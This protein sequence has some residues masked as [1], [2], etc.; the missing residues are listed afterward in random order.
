MMPTW[1]APSERWLWRMVDALGGMLGGLAC[2]DAPASVHHTAWGDVPVLDLGRRA[3]PASVQRGVLAVR[4]FLEADAGRVALVHYLPFAMR[5]GEAWAGLPNRIYVHAH[6]YDLTEDLR[7]PGPDGLPVRFHP[8]DYAR[9]VAQLA[10]RLNGGVLLAN[11][12]RSREKLL[13]MGV[14]P[15]KVM[16]KYLGVPVPP[17]PP[18]RRLRP[19]GMRLLFLGR[20]VDFKGPGETV[21]AFEIARERGLAA[22]LTLAGDGDRSLLPEPLPEAVRWLGAVSGE[23]GDVLRATHDVFVSHS[24]VG[25]VSRQEEALGV[26][27]L[28]AM[29][30]GMPV[31]S[32]SGGSLAEVVE[33]GVSGLL[34][35]PGDVEAEAERLIEL[36]R[37][38]RLYRRLAEG[39]WAAVRERFSMEREARQLRELLRSG[40]PGSG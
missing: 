22:E 4:R 25:P 30:A 13:A 40:L 23:R 1:S 14:A 33:D 34:V 6:G 2:Y 15:E 3:D 21:R 19:G 20:L 16:V 11:S 37:D 5:Y 31:V 29:A 39:A 18:S 27:Y 10:G 9:Q 35:A 36:S 28:E 17:S 24:Q 38:E 32:A 8:P 12:H 26:A 7:R